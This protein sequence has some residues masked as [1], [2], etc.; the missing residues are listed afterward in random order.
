MFTDEGWDGHVSEVV[1]GLHDLGHVVPVVILDQLV[2]VRDGRVVEVQHQLHPGD[3]N[4]QFCFYFLAAHNHQPWPPI[5]RKEIASDHHG[6]C[7]A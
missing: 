2:L 3:H 1:D 4:C 5:K 6:L 7:I